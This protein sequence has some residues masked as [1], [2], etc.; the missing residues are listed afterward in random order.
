MPF[1]QDSPEQSFPP[2]ANQLMQ[3]GYLTLPDLQRALLEQQS[4][5]EALTEIIPRITGKSLPPELWQSYQQNYLF[6]LKILHGVESFNPHREELAWQE[7]QALISSLL[8]LEVCRRLQV[9]PLGL[10]PESSVSLQVAM[11]DPSHQPTVDKLK[12]ILARKSFN[13]ER[14]VIAPKDFTYLLEQ[15]LAQPPAIIDRIEDMTPD[16][17]VDNNFGEAPVGEAPVITLVNKL[18]VKALES[19]ASE[20]HLEPQADVLAVR[21][22]V[23]G[24][25]RPLVNSLPR[26]IAPAVIS[27]LKIMANLYGG[28]AYTSGLAQQGR[29]NR[30]YD[31]RRLDFF[32][33]TLPGV[34]GE[35][36]ILR[37]VDSQSPSLLLDNLVSKLTT[38]EAIGQLLRHPAGLILVTAPSGNGSST[39]WYGLLRDR[40]LGASL[41]ITSLESLIERVIPNVTQVEIKESKGITY[42]GVLDSFLRQ[43]VDIIALDQ[44]PNLEV[45][46]NV[47][48]MALTGHLVVTTLPLNNPST[49]ILHLNKIGMNPALVA[50]ALLGIINQR[51]VRRLCPVCRVANQPDIDTLNKFGLRPNAAKSLTFYQAQELNESEQERAKAKGYL[52]RNCQGF[53]YLGRLGVYEVLKVTPTLKAHIAKDNP[54]SSF[55]SEKLGENLLDYALDLVSQGETTLEEIERVLSDYLPQNLTPVPTPVAPVSSATFLERFQE[56]E[57]LLFILTE[58]VQKIKEELTVSEEIEVVEEKPKDLDID[59]GKVTMINETFMYEELNDPGDWEQL[60]REFDASKETMIAELEDL[61]EDQDYWG[62]KT[63]PDPWNQ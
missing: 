59:L 13:L 62:V 21:V 14:K 37:L 29:F 39:T 63:V 49:A 25:M 30:R 1:S 50:E 36:A 24:M 32:L 11:V 45:G 53:G 5:Q 60:K 33:Q 54:L 40:A 43:D 46:K 61:T 12:T 52:C 22:R 38:R 44:I 51:L 15:Y 20:L 28:N 57:S 23:D 4:S 16:N 31:N 41:N 17:A 48:E 58:K 35:K 8:P 2:L 26:K 9:L 34:E 18:L 27:R 6:E 42:Q 19:R 55:K 56:I 3:A 7:I 47:L 10:K